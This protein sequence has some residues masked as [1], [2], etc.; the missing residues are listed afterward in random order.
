LEE[1]KGKKMANLFK[2]AICVT[3][4]AYRPYPSLFYFPGLTSKPVWKKEAFPLIS[5]CLIANYQTILN[6]YLT[7][8]NNNTESD[9]STSTGD[10]KLHSGKWD[11]YS[12]V[13]KGKK[14]E[15]SPFAKYCPE[16]TKILNSFQNPRLMLN[17]PF[18]YSFFSIL[19]PEATIAS[20][21]APCNL[22]VR[23]HFPLI[24]PSDSRLCGMR[25]ADEILSWKAGNPIFFDD[26]YEHE[27]FFRVF[28][29][30]FCSHFYFYC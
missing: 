4:K 30:L 21:T 16:T 13:L 3:N 24:A 2:S 1:R 5:D 12:Y 27:G 17:T 7:L 20:H 29:A 28:S 8:V 18:S 10:H 11:W 25:V 19:H 9:Y 22:R 26:A 6:E 15:N 23:C 14:Q